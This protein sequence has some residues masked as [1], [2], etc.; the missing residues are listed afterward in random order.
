MYQQ[1]SDK[2]ATSIIFLSHCVYSTR[3]QTHHQTSGNVIVNIRQ[4]SNNYHFCQSLCLFDKD[5]NS[6]TAAQETCSRFNGLWCL[7]L[8]E[9]KFVLFNEDSRTHWFSYHQLLDVKY[10]V[11]VTYFLRGNPLLP[12]RLP[13]P[14]SSNGSLYALSHIQDNTYRKLW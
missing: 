6:R 10:V 5:S 7:I 14:I 2:V 13:F 1:T 3:I 11:I 9:R 4:G 12:H 8:F